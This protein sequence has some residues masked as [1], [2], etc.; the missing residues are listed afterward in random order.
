MSPLDLAVDAIALLLIL[1]R[2]RRVRRVRLH[3]ARRVPLV[4]SGVGLAQFLRYNETHS[5][6]VSSVM[7]VLGSCFIG[8]WALGAL[9][10]ATVELYEVERGSMAQ[11]SGWL[12]MV[13][14]LVS[15]GV[16]FSLAV[17]VSHL[18]G[19]VGALAGSG[20]LFLA[21]TLAVQNALV[22]RRAVRTLMTGGAAVTSMRGVFDAR[23]WEEPRS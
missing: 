23:S 22:H 2:Q 1:Y 10:A 12:T 21:V 8:A 19:P 5:L 7:V 13:L 15:V 11:R 4:L 18:G 6:G 17:V 20:A 9:R 3:F 16:H 14:W